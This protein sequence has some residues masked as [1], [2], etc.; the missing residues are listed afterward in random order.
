MQLQHNFLIHIYWQVLKIILIAMVSNLWDII[1]LEKSR[2]LYVGFNFE[3]IKTNINIF[4]K[5]PFLSFWDT[6]AL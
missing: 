3:N 1:I 6:A 2:Q 4:F 5:L